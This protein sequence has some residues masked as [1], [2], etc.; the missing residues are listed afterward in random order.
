MK[1]GRTHWQHYFG[2]FAVLLI[3][4]QLLTGLFLT[5]FYLPTLQEAYTSVKFLYNDLASWAWLRDTHR[6]ASLAIF[7]SI[8]IHAVRSFYRGDF[9]HRKKRVLW[10]TGVFLVVPMTLFLLTGLILPWEWKGYWFME[11]VPN[12]L[13][14]IPL[15]GPSL[16]QFS[17]DA[18]TLPRDLVA[19]ILI[20]PI[21]SI[22]L[23]D[24]HCFTKLRK[25]GV[26]KYLGK[27]TLIT[28]PLLA[29]VIVLAFYIPMPTQDPEIIPLP[30]DGVNIPASEWILLLFMLPFMY[31][32]GAMA[33][34]LG[35]LVPLVVFLALAFLPYYLGR[36]KKAK[37]KDSDDSPIDALA[38][39]TENPPADTPTDKT[40]VNN[41]PGAVLR[42][43]KIVGTFILVLVTVGVLL[44]GA[45][46]GTYKSPTLGCGSCHNLYLGNRMGVPP[47][48]FK[49]RE[50]MPLLDDN[51]WMMRHWFN[52]QIVW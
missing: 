52:P 13:G 25:K 9:A 37:T 16:K 40:E 18:F 23:I 20:L 27:H 11:M 41:K 43:A 29:G 34:F 33:P 45:T 22:I 31:F 4:I 12:Y 32:K 19:H 17:I 21:I 26:F 49:D 36:K 10:L 47:K 30:L 2:G 6:W 46:Y 1:I 42:F 44:G 24:I 51:E 48:T 38:D 14:A 8:V 15:I 3:L 28:V 35:L 39:T 50:T 5:M 7:V